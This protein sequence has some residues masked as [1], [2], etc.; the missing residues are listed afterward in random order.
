LSKAG[1]YTTTINKAI[2][3]AVSNKNKQ[4]K[5]SKQFLCFKNIFENI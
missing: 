2:A 1:W 5:I 4:I 3:E